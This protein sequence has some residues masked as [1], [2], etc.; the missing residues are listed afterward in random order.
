[1]LELTDRTHRVVAFVLPQFHPI[2]ENDEWW[3]IGFTEWTNVAKARPLFPG[4]DQPHLPADLGF[5]DLRLP[6]ARAAQALLASGYG[7]DAFC[8]HHY[9]FHG[10]RLLERPVN[11]IV[12]SGEPAFPF[13]LCWA[14]ESW[15]RAWDGGNR[16]ILIEQRYDADD[17][18]AHI[19]ALAPI[20]AD[21][22]YL[23][24]DGKP[25]FLVYRSGDLP[26]PARTT[27]IWR[28]EA[29]RLGLGE[30]YLCRAE[31]FP[32]RTGDPRQW[33]FDAAV[34]FQPDWQSPGP[35]PDIGFARRV[36]RRILNPG[37]GRRHN[38]MR[39]YEAMVQ[40]SLSRP[41]ESYV[42]Y[43]CVTPRFDNSPRRPNGGATIFLGSTPEA[44]GRWL[45]GT[46]TRFVP[47]TEA[48]NL[49][50]VNAWNEWGEGNHL[51]PDHRWGRA[52]LEAHCVAR[53]VAQPRGAL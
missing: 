9:W 37:D 11:D 41:E 3:G 28:A 47:P 17:D 48:E 21:P 25:A 10:R 51:E 7:V 36:V 6:E 29:A 19:R 5:Y 13:M 14:N 30:L 45:S 43:P 34:D 50:F 18:L 27:D 53:E 42:R 31:A 1:M 38:A 49:V 52:Y 39:S 26:D 24:V 35:R 23:R 20:L 4:H 2:P 33:G 22:R 46:L 15:T 16:Q 8:Y 32:P 12:R 44:Y 40:L